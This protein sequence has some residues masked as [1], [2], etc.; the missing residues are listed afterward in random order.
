MAA[1]DLLYKVHV[2]GDIERRVL[3]TVDTFVGMQY[4][5]HAPLQR[6]AS[7]FVRGCAQS[8]TVRRQGINTQ[9]L[10]KQRRNLVFVTS[11]GKRLQPS[12]WPGSALWASRRRTE[13]R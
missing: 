11:V 5:R 3:T 6:G 4:S 12:S 1:N 2:D 8:V 7:S 9:P 10:A 13:V